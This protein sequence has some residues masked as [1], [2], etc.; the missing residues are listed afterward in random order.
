MF[1]LKHCSPVLNHGWLFSWFRDSCTQAFCC[2][3]SRFLLYLMQVTL[4]FT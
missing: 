1:S 3:Q 4:Y 2:C